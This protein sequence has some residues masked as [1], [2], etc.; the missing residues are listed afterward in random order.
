VAAGGGCREANGAD[1]VTTN[2]HLTACGKGL[3]SGDA[4]CI[5]TAAAIVASA[6]VMEVELIPG[7][8]RCP[9]GWCRPRHA[10]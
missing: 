10:P 6:A 2:G 3:V 8:M 9:R 1:G 7:R 4:A 5:A